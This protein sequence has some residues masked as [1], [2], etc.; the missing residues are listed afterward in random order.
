MIDC[1]LSQGGFPLTIPLLDINEADDSL[2]TF[3]RCLHNAS[4]HFSQKS[5]G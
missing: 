4:M 1:A 3:E 2:Q 5:G